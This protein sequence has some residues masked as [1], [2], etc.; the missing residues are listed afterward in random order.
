ME[1]KKHLREKLNVQAARLQGL[2][3][4]YNA[5]ESENVR[6]RGNIDELWTSWTRCMEIV[7]TQ[8]AKFKELE[9]FLTGENV[10]R[11]KDPFNGKWSIRYAISKE[12]LSTTLSRLELVWDPIAHS[13]VFE[14]TVVGNQQDLVM[15]VDRL[16]MIMKQIAHKAAQPPKDEYGH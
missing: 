1:R 3:N 5:L 11:E 12:S 14:V 10:Y 15:T 16:N 2:Q 8:D 4:E 6:L 9:S 13:Y 7:K